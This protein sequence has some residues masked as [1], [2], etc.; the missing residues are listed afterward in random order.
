MTH[1]LRQSVSRLACVGARNHGHDTGVDHPQ[2]L[3]TVH[4]QGLVDDTTEL[5]RHHCG[6]TNGVVVSRRQIARDKGLEVRVG[7]DVGAGGVLDGGELV[8]KR[9]LEIVTAHKLD[10]LDEEV[11]LDGVRQRAVVDHRLRVEGVRRVDVDAAA[12]EGLHRHGA[13]GA[14]LRLQQHT[15]EGRILGAHLGGKELHLRLVAGDDGGVRVGGEEAGVVLLLQ[16][17]GDLLGI[18]R[19][20]GKG[21]PA[22]EVAECDGVWAGPVGCPHLIGPVLELVSIHE[23]V[24]VGV[25]ISNL[26]H[27]RDVSN[28]RFSRDAI[29]IQA[30]EHLRVMFIVDRLL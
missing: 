21:E 17:G 27:Y 15:G 29:L 14:L 19:D 2:V 6:R 24:R 22:G 10:V 12:A 13:L 25:D 11:D 4:T 9:G 5:Q 18:L 28:Y 1:L 23:V 20:C 8:L 3:D 30:F 7:G 26:R 16:L